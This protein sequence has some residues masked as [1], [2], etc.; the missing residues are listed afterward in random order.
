MSQ[1]DKLSKALRLAKR[2]DIV[3]RSLGVSLI[4]GTVL[5]LINQGDALFSTDELNIWKGLLTYMVPYL[6][7]SYGSVMSLIKLEES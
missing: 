5:N 6:V 1:F 4:L 2:P 3:K 7:T